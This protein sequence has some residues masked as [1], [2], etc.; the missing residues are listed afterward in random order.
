MEG[1]GP[2]SEQNSDPFLIRSSRS[3]KARVSETS[4]DHGSESPSPA[5]SVNSSTNKK[6][7]NLKSIS[8]EALQ[9]AFATASPRKWN[10]K[11]VAAIV[12]F[13]LAG[14]LDAFTSMF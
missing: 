9:P 3:P 11:T 4:A 6:Y 5:K 1:G 14:K 12:G 13:Q 2:E 8:I 10:K 7:L